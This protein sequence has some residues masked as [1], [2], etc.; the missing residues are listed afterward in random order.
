LKVERKTKHKKEKTYTE[1][2]E[3]GEERGLKEKRPDGGR[4]ASFYRE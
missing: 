3:N 1:N 4:G 2:A